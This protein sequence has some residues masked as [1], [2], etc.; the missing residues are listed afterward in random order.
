MNGSEWALKMQPDIYWSKHM[1]TFE[2][3]Y[4]ET[5]GT[6]SADGDKPDIDGMVL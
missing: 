6:I 2:K 4:V 3:Q 5:M 1:V